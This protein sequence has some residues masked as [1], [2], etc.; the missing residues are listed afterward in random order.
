MQIAFNAT[1]LLSPLTGIGQY[2]YELASRMAADPEHDAEFFYAVGWSKEVRQAPLSMA[3]GLFPM[4]RRFL[5]N[6]YAVSRWVQGRYFRRRTQERRFDVY[7]EPNFLAYPFDGPLV[8]TVHDLSWIRFP[9]AHP[10]ERVAAMN[11]FFEP[12]LRRSTLVLTDSEFVKREVIEVFGI[13]PARIVPIPLGVG[14]HFRPA[15]A[16]AT[17]D[18]MARQGLAH[19]RYLLCVGT[20]EPRK[21]LIT[22]LRAHAG[23][24]AATRAAYPLVL[25]GIKGWH[26]EA[27]EKELAPRVAAGE[28][29]LT[30]Y[31]SRD[32]LALLTAGATAL[33]Y[34]SIYE[35]FGLPP[36][37]A[38]ACGVPPITSNA[39]SLPEVVGDAGMVVAP[40]DQ[41][42]LRECMAKVIGDT[43]LRAALSAR[44][45][46]RAKLF[47]WDA[48]YA[49]TVAAYRQAAK[50]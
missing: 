40:H 32:D 30:G 3:P 26:T 7:H 44:S 14:A 35:G 2:A 46:E 33:V 16:T 19:G 48:C 36:L 4:V 27:L 37:E 28:V 39:A 8:T 24:D 50:A 12:G 29:K 34:P 18:L 11:R 21:N 42:G 43:T 45:L 6:S 20:L 5:P 10:K 9:E 41:D 25:A 13:D 31:L 47:S 15:D 23:L 22:A 17:A 38:M 49:A 1:A